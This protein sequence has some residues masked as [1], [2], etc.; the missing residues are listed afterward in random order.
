MKVKEIQTRLTSKGLKITPQRIAILN[1]ILTL[2]NHPTA[3]EIVAFVHKD[4]PNI[5]VGTVYQTLDVF[6]ENKLV[7]RVKTDRDVMRYDGIISG[8]HHLYCSECDLIEDYFDDELDLLLKEYFKK[9]EIKGFKMEDIVLQ[10]RGTF[11]K[12]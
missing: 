11:D 4:N 1:A 8:H 10:I 2:N 3:D 5:A 6:I 7:K 12:C 9:K